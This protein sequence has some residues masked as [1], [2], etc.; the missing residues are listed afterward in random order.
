[1]S[2]NVPFR[3]KDVE[4]EFGRYVKFEVFG[5]I[6][7]KERWRR[8]QRHRSITVLAENGRFTAENGRI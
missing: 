3:T 8:L 2:H 6:W 7:G 1:M 4:A 5:R